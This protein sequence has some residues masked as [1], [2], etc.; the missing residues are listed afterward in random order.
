MSS[1]VDF[2]MIGRPQSHVQRDDAKIDMDTDRVSVWRGYEKDLD[3][4]TP[5]IAHYGS[6]EKSSRVKRIKAAWPLSADSAMQSSETLV[7]VP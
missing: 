4:A 5:L 6:R 1:L 2:Q 3:V 7:K